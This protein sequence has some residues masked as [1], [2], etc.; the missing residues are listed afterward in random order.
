MSTEQRPE[1][2]TLGPLICLNGAIVHDRR[3]CVACGRILTDDR[4]LSVKLATKPHYRRFFDHARGCQPCRAGAAEH[5]AQ[6]SCT[7]G[8][9]LLWACCQAENH[10]Q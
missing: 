7:G 4:P 2:A 6:L 10:V 5:N 1:V 3:A 8:Q 9:Q